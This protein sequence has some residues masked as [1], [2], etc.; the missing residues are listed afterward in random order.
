MSLRAHFRIRSRDSNYATSKGLSLQHDQDN[1]FDDLRQKKLRCRKT[2]DDSYGNISLQQMQLRSAIRG[3]S[4]DRPHPE[5]ENSLA[6]FNS[7]T[8]INEPAEK[9]KR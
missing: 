6:H 3:I 1:W 5:K 2:L 9:P 8:S 7:Q 4:A